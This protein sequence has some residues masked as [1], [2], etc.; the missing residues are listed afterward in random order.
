MNRKQKEKTRFKQMGSILLCFLFLAAIIFAER[1]GI[2]YQEIHHEA[3][4]LPETFESSTK[5][6]GDERVC[7]LVV[8]STEENSRHAEP[9]LVQILTDMRVG[10]D[11][12]DIAEEA[13]PD[14]G[15]YQTAVIAVSNLDHIGDAVLELCEWVKTGGGAMFPLTLQKSTYLDLVAAKMGIL[16]VNDGNSLVE[17]IYVKEG[18][19]L[20][21]GRTFDITDAYESALTL[22]VSEAAQVHMTTED[23]KLPL[24]WSM[25][26]GKGR[27]VIDNFGLNEK[28]YRG[29]YAASYSLLEDVS[30][31]PVINGS[32]FY[33]DDFP[34]PVPSGE[35]KYI[36]R[37][38]G[39]TI[40]D[41]YTNYWW[42][43]MM[44]LAKKYG[45]AYTGL[46]IE[47][48][49][50]QVSGELPRNGEV[51]RYAYFGN[52]MLDMGGELGFHGY[53]HQPLCLDNFDYEIDLGYETWASMEAMME[54]VTELT[55]FSKGIFP[56]ESFSVY[57]P[58]SNILS[59][60]GR[61]MLSEEFPEIKTIASIYFS[62]E[63]AYEQEFEV[64][65]DGMVE[66]PRIISGCTIGEYMQI[67]AVSELNMH[68]VNSHFLHPDDLL[69]EDRGAALGWETLKKS[70]ETYLEWLFT[71][72]PD[73]RSLT[74]SQLAG[75]V[76]RY[77]SVSLWKKDTPDDFYLTVDGLYD[78]AYFFMR[79][80]EGQVGEAKGADMTHLT[81]N[82]YLLRVTEQDVEITRSR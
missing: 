32:A 54:S 49:G 16:E 43:D 47:N 13:L 29:F 65:E 40:A 57:V 71:S 31:Y 14:M 3:S 41:F 44:E 19:M 24:I 78:E 20:G 77:S 27:F 12:V 8:D 52:M 62:G 23:G 64:A 10:F 55:D 82:L 2:H 74:G 69:D 75:A 73:I 15:R 56:K 30:V 11:R 38:Y 61:K 22:Q 9:E 45:M 67:A 34:S 18:F 37:D 42:T 70:W 4:Y 36:Q 68:Y 17:T 1:K 63:S 33:I 72:A 28:A 60:E 80:N 7:L 51:S 81:G 35:G 50:N 25:E 58:P 66:T 76:E 21:G 6:A 26:Y 79:V 53:N 59:P 46:I 48:Y 5:D 39:T